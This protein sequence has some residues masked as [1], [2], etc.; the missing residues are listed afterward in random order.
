MQL[1]KNKQKT[2]VILLLLGVVIGL[3]YFK[4]S[5]IQ[6]PTINPQLQQPINKE[7]VSQYK[8][9]ENQSTTFNNQTIPSNIKTYK[10]S[11]QT[12]DF[13]YVKDVFSSLGYSNPKTQNNL[14]FTEDLDKKTMLLANLKTRTLIYSRQYS[15]NPKLPGEYLK[16]AEQEI[17]RFIGNSQIWENPQHFIENNS[18]ESIIIHF[19]PTINNY[20][21][22][23]SSS[24]PIGDNGV[25]KVTFYPQTKKITSNI[26]YIDINQS[27]SAQ[28]SL[29]GVSQVEADIANNQSIT[30]A[31]HLSSNQDE[32]YYQKPHDVKNAVFNEFEIMYLY[33]HQDPTNYLRPIVLAEGQT[34]I[35][36]GEKATI[37]TLLDLTKQ[38]N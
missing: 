5:Q 18:K 32:N 25:I 15:Q 24:P 37:K 17:K 9:P 10:Q 21:I 13:K 35:E 16:I 26:E 12:F 20:R 4:I 11:P 31:I 14:I 38:N 2:I 19:F 6:T 33:N 3:I 1:L 8:Q 23:T 28:I 29:K 34:I 36:T 7:A 27:D 30:T 22:T